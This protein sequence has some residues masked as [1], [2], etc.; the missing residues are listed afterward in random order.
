MARIADLVTEAESQ[1]AEAFIVTAGGPLQ[2]TAPDGSNY[3][4]NDFSEEHLN[5]MVEGTLSPDQLTDLMVGRPV[6]M[7][8]DVEGS[9]WRL[10]VEPGVNGL[11]V[12]GTRAKP[13]Q[14]VQVEAAPESAAGPPGVDD[15]E[16]NLGEGSTLAAGPSSDVGFATSATS[17]FGLVDP[18]NRELE[19]PSSSGSAHAPPPSMHDAFESLD[20]GE[21]PP[22][23]TPE[24]AFSSGVRPMLDPQIDVGLD[25]SPDD[26]SFEPE[27]DEAPLVMEHEP[28]APDAEAAAQAAEADD[29]A[30]RKTAKTPVP[31]DSAPRFAAPGAG[32]SQGTLMSMRPPGLEAGM[33]AQGGAPRK[34]GSAKAKVSV[35]RTPTGQFPRSNELEQGSLCFVRELADAV[36][37]GTRLGM[38]VEVIHDEDISEGRGPTVEQLGVEAGAA[39]IVHIDDPSVLLGWILLRREEGFRV[40]VVTRAQRPEGARR[41]LM[42]L[43]ANERIE[44]WVEAFPVVAL[45]GGDYMPL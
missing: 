12:R 3:P 40:F 25:E 18:D 31:P 13:R 19:M 14:R 26:A 5:E 21:D 20:F 28:V 44:A 15:F 22:P 4:L 36:Q 39:L 37:A 33:L 42:G 30:N 41:V 8:L 7:S 10:L 16:I 24:D 34:K 1:F 6:G 11:T 23:P 45:V 35:P 29:A 38:G 2:V 9:R 17:G 27:P 43:H 32:R